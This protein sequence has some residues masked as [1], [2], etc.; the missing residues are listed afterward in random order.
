MILCGTTLRVENGQIIVRP[1]LSSLPNLRGRVMIPMGPV[2]F[3]Y[4]KEDS[5]QICGLTLPALAVVD[6]IESNH[7]AVTVRRN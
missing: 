4:R 2:D 3:D 6:I 5:K 1:D 7:S